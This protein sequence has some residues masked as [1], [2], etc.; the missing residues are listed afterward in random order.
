MKKTKKLA[1]AGQLVTPPSSAVDLCDRTD[2]LIAD[3]D[4]DRSLESSAV[5]FDILSVSHPAHFKS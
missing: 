3:A 1:L 4:V 5:S 2:Q